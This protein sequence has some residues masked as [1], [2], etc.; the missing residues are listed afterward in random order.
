MRLIFAMGLIA[1]GTACGQTA[2]NLSF[3]V[4]SIKPGGDVF[5]TRPDR[6]KGRIRWTTQLNYLIGYAYRLDF[7][8]VSGPKCA[9][10]YSVEAIFDPAASEDQLRLMLQSLL[11]ERFKLELHRVT[12]QSDGYALVIG[13]G[14]LKVKEA[15]DSD[16][17]PPMPEWVKDA[18]PALKAQTFISAI[19]PERGVNAIIGRRASISQLA[20][21]LQRG[22][23]MPVWD[24]TGLSG[25]YYFAFRYVKEVAPDVATDAPSLATAL[26]ESLGLKMEK[27]KGPVE[28]LVIGHVEEPSEN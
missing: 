3:E 18:S 1:A 5:S 21:I 6:T 9:S 27:Q 26:K 15:H 7:S 13:N 16:E 4:A 23:N 14:G 28:T 11:V 19:V 2:S 24:R 20:E 22:T 8:R 17:P 12:T 10:I 25:N